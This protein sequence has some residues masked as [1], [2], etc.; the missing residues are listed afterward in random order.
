MKYFNPVAVKDRKI[1]EWLTMVEQEM[2]LTLARLLAQA[3]QDIAEFHSKTIDQEKFM[4]WVDRYQSQLVVLAAQISWSESAEKA[5]QAIE[6]KG[7]KD[8][9]PMVNV[10]QVVEAT[11]NVLADSVLHEQPPVRRKKLEHLV[12]KSSRLTSVSCSPES[13]KFWF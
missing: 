10:L 4:Q 7:D 1:N 11:L 3:V 12:S 9:T 13:M 2:R 8:V 6:Q 5:L